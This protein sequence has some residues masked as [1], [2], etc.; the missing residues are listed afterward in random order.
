MAETIQDVLYL[1]TASGLAFRFKAE[2][3]PSQFQRLSGAKLSIDLVEES[4]NG[5]IQKQTI[6]EYS[7]NKSRTESNGAI[8]NGN[9]A[10]VDDSF[11]SYRLAQSLRVS[12]NLLRR[13][14]PSISAI[15]DNGNLV[16]VAIDGGTI[17]GYPTLKNLIWTA[18]VGSG[19]SQY[20]IGAAYSNELGNV[21]QG[22]FIGGDGATTLNTQNPIAPFTVNG[23]PR[24][25][26]YGETIW[27]EPV[28]L[29]NGIGINIDAGIVD[30]M[31]WQPGGGVNP[32]APGVGT[33]PYIMTY[34]HFVADGQ[35]HITMGGAVDE[36]RIT[37]AS[38]GDWKNEFIKYTQDASYTSEQGQGL[39]KVQS[40]P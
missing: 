19:Q 25:W 17:V 3:S 7:I 4:S 24:P 6:F 18:G 11:C 40:L 26:I 20:F 5:W 29:N 23:N 37:Q 1:R 8:P 31:A 16:G 39:R 35:G 13:D 28:P 2:D 30:S 36:L 22:T 14:R 21:H 12:E 27:L 32:A 33:T 38:P 15:V 34:G 10:Y 9:V